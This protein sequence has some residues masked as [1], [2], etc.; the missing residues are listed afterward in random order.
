MMCSRLR[1]GCTY[2]APPVS[3]LSPEVIH[4]CSSE[5][6]KAYAYSACNMDVGYRGM[7]PDGSRNLSHHE[8]E[9]TY[10]SADL[11]GMAIRLGE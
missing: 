9:C 3:K 10:K 6:F 7:L 4:A 2:C 11:D 5:F 8:P 1:A